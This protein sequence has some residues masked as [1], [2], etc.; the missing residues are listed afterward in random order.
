LEEMEAGMEALE[1]MEAE[2]TL[3]WEM[4]LTHEEPQPAALDLEQNCLRVC[5][6]TKLVSLVV[7]DS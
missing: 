1:E 3:P 6:D 2:E 4:D 5:Q 7:Q